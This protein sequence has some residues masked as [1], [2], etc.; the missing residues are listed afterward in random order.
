MNTKEYYSGIKKNEVLI[1]AIMMILKI[2]TLNEKSQIQKAAYCLTPFYEMSKIGKPTD[3]ESRLLVALGLGEGRMLNGYG[4][5]LWGDE[6][7]LE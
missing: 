7:V 4:V 3:T 1:H 6:N 5:S 2:I